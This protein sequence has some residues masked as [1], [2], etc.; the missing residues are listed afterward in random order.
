MEIYLA[1]HEFAVP[2]NPTYDADA[3]ARHWAALRVLNQGRFRT[4]DR[5]RRPEPRFAGRRCYTR[6]HA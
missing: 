4:P 2:D 3:E 1:R 6:M 5:A